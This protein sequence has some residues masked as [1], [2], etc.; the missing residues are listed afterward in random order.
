V[1]ASRLLGSL[2]RADERRHRRSQDWLSAQFAE[3]RLGILQVDDIETLCHNH[4]PAQEVVC[5]ELDVSGRSES[6]GY[7][8]RI[9]L[10]ALT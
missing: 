3:E 10:P 9:R 6:T 2:I 4:I 1:D 8:L 5:H 7:L